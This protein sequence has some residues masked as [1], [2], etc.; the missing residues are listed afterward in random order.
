MEIVKMTSNQSIYT[1]TTEIFKS[2]KYDGYWVVGENFYIAIKKKPTE[3]Q[4]KNTK[5]L[6]GW[7][8]KDE[9]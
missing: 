5:E 6:L 2:P 9:I 4:I 3:Q 7:E 1:T 8:W